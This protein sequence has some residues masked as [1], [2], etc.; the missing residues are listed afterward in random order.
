MN[1][2]LKMKRTGSY[3]DFRAETD[4]T[5]HQLLAAVLWI[6]LLELENLARGHQSGGGG[7]GWVIGLPVRMTV[8][9]GASTGADTR[10]ATT[11]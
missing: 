1:G 5:G 3:L 6:V 8:Q 10:H 11:P 9:T 4:Q 2:E 7:G